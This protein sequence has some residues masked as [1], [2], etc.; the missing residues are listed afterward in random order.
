MSHATIVFEKDAVVTG[1]K[2]LQSVVENSKQAYEV[3]VVGDD[4]YV[5]VKEIKEKKQTLDEVR[6]LAGNIAR[7]LGKRKVDEAKR[8]E[9][10]TS[11]LQ[12]RGHLVCRLLLEK[13]KN[14]SILQ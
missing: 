12:S 6:M 7:D 5:I 10:H 9:E 2:T 13:K 8:S 4:L 14:T 11:E 3:Q 1:N